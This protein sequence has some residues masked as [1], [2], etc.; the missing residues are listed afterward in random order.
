V[1]GAR[2]TVLIPHLNSTGVPTNPTTP[3]TERSIDGAAFADCTEEVTTIGGTATGTSFLTLTGDETNC[4]IL[5]LAAKAA[6]G[7]QTTLMHLY[8]RVLAVVHAGTAQAGAAGSIT[9]AAGAA[10]ID[11]YSA[12]CIVRTPGG[13]GGGGGSGSQNNQARVVTSYAGATRVATV[14]P[15]WEVPPGATTTYEVH[16]ADT[17]LLTYGDLQGWRG[18]A[19]NA[20]VAGRVDGFAGALAAGVVEAASFAAGAIDAAALAADAVGAAELS[21]AAAN[22]IADALLDRANGVETNYTARQALRLILAACAGKLS[23]AAT[24]T[25]TIRDVN[26]AVDRVVATVDASGN[27]SAVTL[28]P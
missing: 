27:R 26:D 6:S 12:G 22:K 14:V 4:A 3:D 10:A 5:A 21:A 17:A 9:L 15:N 28:T 13:T 23:G 8:P 16:V 11:G 19:P 24:A 7:P 18:A 25:V 2:F 20:L 1:R